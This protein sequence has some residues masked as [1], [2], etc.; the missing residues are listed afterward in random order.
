M[1]MRRIFAALAAVVMVVG[2]FVVWQSRRPDSGASGPSSTDT[3]VTRSLK[4]VWCVPEAA[5]ACSQLPDLTVEILAPAQIESRVIKSG[6]S[7]TG[8]GV[9]AIVATRH[10]LERWQPMSFGLKIETTAIASTELVAVEKVGGP[11]CAGNLVCLLKAGERLA[12]PSLDATTSGTIAAALALKALGV[13]SLADDLDPAVVR[14]TATVKTSL[15]T[16]R[17]SAEALS[18]LLTVRL[19]DAAVMTRAEFEAASPAG[20]T[21][22][23][24][25]P[26]ASVTLHIGGFG[27]AGL[28]DVRSELA[29]LLRTA[30]WAQPTARTSSPSAEFLNQT[31]NLLR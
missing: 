14:S 28:S 16:P 29:A 22:T 17:T 2:G 31:Y 3:S 15:N 11:G 9:D 7:S 25:I 30:G 10:W 27:S 6:S 8:L 23:A 18:A 1:A 26:Q 21:A 13:T 24:L 12:L 4:T 5:L 20:A 19:L